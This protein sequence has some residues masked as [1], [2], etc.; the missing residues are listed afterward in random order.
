M[1]LRVAMLRPETTC[2]QIQLPRVGSV[3]EVCAHL[4]GDGDLAAALKML[5][6][7]DGSLARDNAA[8]NGFVKDVT[9]YV[10]WYADEFFR[11]RLQA[12]RLWIDGAG[13]SDTVNRALFEAT[14]N[15]GAHMPHPYWTNR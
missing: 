2:I 5:A 12:E 8:G 13:G 1:S 7:W 3:R 10:T 15:F 6:K 4:K 9:P 14:W 11:L